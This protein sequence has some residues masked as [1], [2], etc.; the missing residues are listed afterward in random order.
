MTL[1]DWFPVWTPT[2]IRLAHIASRAR[3]GLYR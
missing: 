2:T 3:L 1:A